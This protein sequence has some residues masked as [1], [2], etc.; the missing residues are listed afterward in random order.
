M[1][2]VE[3]LEKKLG[4]RGGKGLQ[5]FHVRAHVDHHIPPYKHCDDETIRIMNRIRV[6][7]EVYDWPRPAEWINLKIVFQ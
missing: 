3:Y 6:H 1:E 2:G 7:N 4:N 5:W